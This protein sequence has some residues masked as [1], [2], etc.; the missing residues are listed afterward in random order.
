MT[1]WQDIGARLGEARRAIGLTQE[2][3]AEKVGLDPLAVSHIE[4]GASRVGAVELTRLADSLELPVDYF[5]VSPPSVLSHR[6]PME[7][8][9]SDATR[10]AF[11]TQALLGSWLRDVRQLVDLGFLPRRK[12]WTYPE[13]REG[14]GAYLDYL[15]AARWVRGELGNPDDPLGPM[16]DVCAEAGQWPL[17]AQIP[18]DGAS[19]IDGDI[20]VS[21]I[22]VRGEPGRRRATAAHEL[23]HLVMGDAYSNDLGVHVSVEERERAIERFAAELLLPV[24]AIQRNWSSGKEPR[25]QLMTLAARYRV[26]W[27]LALA[28]A[29]RARVID[30]PSRNALMARTPTRAEFL[31]ALGWTPEPDLQSIRVAPAYATAVLDALKGGKVTRA[32][33][34]EMLHGQVGQDDLPS[35]NE[36]D[37]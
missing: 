18:G 27:T 21:I 10:S 25:D 3:L 31:Q 29:E 4:S 19:L 9:E 22:S 15:D 36:V 13:K 23:G 16:V 1:S 20:A 35:Q 5:L 6:M 17:V 12:P 30:M 33:A 28:Q 2:Q 32:R 8:N 14:A 24:T 26:S 37:H 7:E 34:A 11:R